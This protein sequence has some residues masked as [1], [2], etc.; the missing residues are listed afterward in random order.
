MVIV[1]MA[2]PVL[3]IDTWH[4]YFFSLCWMAE[5]TV[6]ANLTDEIQAVPLKF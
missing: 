4:R 6:G 3:H 1:T 2:P 5:M